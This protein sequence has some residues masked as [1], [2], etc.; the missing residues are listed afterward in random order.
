M[1]D[2]RT[3]G[4]ATAPRKSCIDGKEKARD[5][6]DVMS[7]WRTVADRSS[8]S[9]SATSSSSCE[10]RVCPDGW[11]SFGGF[12]ETAACYPVILADGG[13]DGQQSS[14]ELVF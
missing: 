5:W 6:S 13:D 12:P 9:A 8:S 10:C 1:E 4:W 3:A 14:F 2:G 11:T 7:K